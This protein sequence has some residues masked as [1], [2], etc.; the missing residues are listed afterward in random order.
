MQNPRRCHNTEVIASTHAQIARC[1]TNFVHATT[2]S[3]FRRWAWSRARKYEL[4][5]MSCEAPRF[6][7]LVPRLSLNIRKGGGE[8][9][10]SLANFIVTFRS[11]CPLFFRTVNKVL[12][13]IHRH[14]LARLYI[15]SANAL[16]MRGFT[17]CS[18]SHVV[19]VTTTEP[20]SAERLPYAKFA[21]LSLPSER[22]WVRD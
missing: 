12:T 10:E 3:A 9:R 18:H 16:R 6:F 11:G 15:C 5:C 20:E 14:R 7:S 2:P 13:H 21:R 17:P 8:E 1:R 4:A 19:V 22:V